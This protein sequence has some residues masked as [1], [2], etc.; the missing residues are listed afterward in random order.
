[1][2][3]GQFI[4]ETTS[5]LN[6]AGIL[7]ARLDTLVL[8][9]DAWHK[10]KAWLLA[11]TDQKIPAH[12]LS[13]ISPR[14]AARLKHKPMAYIRG[15]Q[16]FYGRDFVVNKRVLIPRPESE[17]LIDLLKPLAQ[18]AP[19]ILIDVGTGSGALGITA[20]LE[21]PN[22]EVKLTD[23]DPLALEV[24]NYNA[25]RLKLRLQFYLGDLLADFNSNHEYPYVQFI[26]ANLPYV[27]KKW[28]RSSETN[29]EPSIALFAKDGGLYLIKKL[30]K[31][32][33]KVLKPGGYLLLESDPRQHDQIIDFANQNSLKL[34]DQKGFVLVFTRLARKVQA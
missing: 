1:M 32:A 4:K 17:A 7:T 19:G 13:A 34:V 30:I 16:E 2:N 28:E 31:Q 22:L 10:D 5:K 20:A 24:A 3:L 25:R 23:I 21:C 11:N 9:S 27:D 8:I 15:H 6:A 33:A 14:L 26:I 29:Y 12:V 18:K